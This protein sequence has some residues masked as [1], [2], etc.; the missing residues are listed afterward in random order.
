MIIRA[1]EVDAMALGPAP[2]AFIST[3]RLLIGPDDI[4]MLLP[5]GA[6]L[7]RKRA[8]MLVQLQGGPKDAPKSLEV[9]AR[10]SLLPLPCLVQQPA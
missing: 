3:P 6:E 4:N 8:M 9:R 7:R 5:V 1:I 2:R 10:T